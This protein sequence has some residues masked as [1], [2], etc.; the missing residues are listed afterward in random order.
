M[1]RDIATRCATV[2]VAVAKLVFKGVAILSVIAIIFTALYFI[3]EPFAAFGKW[4][5]D[6]NIFPKVLF[7]ILAPGAAALAN[8][9]KGN[10]AEQA[11]RQEPRSVRRAFTQATDEQTP[12]MV[13]G[14]LTWLAFTVGAIALGQIVGLFQ[15]PNCPM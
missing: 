15:I 10:L 3:T 7:L 11:K 12:E 14:W 13:M 5:A 4:Y 8:Q 6:N 1:I 9:I 2:T